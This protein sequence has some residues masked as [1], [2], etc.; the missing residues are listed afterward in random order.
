MKKVLFK[1]KKAFHLPFLAIIGPGLIATA[2]GNDAG[3][4]ATYAVAGARFGLELLWIML[5]L[6]IAFVLVQEMAVRLGAVTGKGFSDL[7]RE[8]FPIKATVLMMFLIFVS[9]AGLVVSEFLGIAAALELFGVSKYIGVPISAIFI[10]WLVTKGNY[11]KVEKL[12]LLMSAVLLSY[13]IAPFLLKINAYHV[14]NSFVVP[15]LPKSPGALAMVV[16]LVGTT[17]APFMQIYAQA[18]VVE[19]GITTTD[20][21]LERFDSL[22]GTLFA[23]LVAVFII[24]TTAST[25]FPNQIGIETAGEAA[26]ALA[27]LAGDFA[28]IL[29]GI[30]LLGA[31]LLAAGV[32]P[33]TTSFALTDAFGWEAGVNRTLDE[34]P[35]FYA[36]F[37]FL[38]VL[39][40][41]ITLSPA[42]SIIKLLL[43]LQVLNGILLPIQLFFM[44]KLA[45]DKRLMGNYRNSLVFNI[46]VTSATVIIGVAGIVFVGQTLFSLI[47]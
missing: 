40:A 13:I 16:G 46:I 11:H 47:A 31:S 43:S 7:V 12:F 28:K 41:T 24:I 15:S 6:T 2:A 4:I 33:L 26:M 22:I 3:G 14:L 39:S 25:L 1:F 27:P 35:I 34:A 45:N 44:L 10:W 37:T 32:V 29:F 20:L 18:A 21:K 30:G 17:I 36:I 23:N 5:P 42:I 38:I 8:N 9:N 19:K